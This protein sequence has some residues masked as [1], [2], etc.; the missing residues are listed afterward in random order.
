MKNFEFFPFVVDKHNNVWKY[1]KSKDHFIKLTPWKQGEDRRVN[2]FEIEKLI[3]K[4][5]LTQMKNK[6][7]VHEIINNRWREVD[8]SWVF[9]GRTYYVDSF[10]SYNDCMKAPQHIFRHT[11]KDANGKEH[12]YFSKYRLGFHNGKIVWFNPYH[13]F[14]QLYIW[15]F[16]DINKEPEGYNSWS[17]AKSIRPIYNDKHEI[18]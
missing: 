10:K 2:R 7:A 3:V 11:H 8:F 17:N 14:P 12:E 15:A 6:P 1:I 18:I 5:A 13:Y 9:R 16:E 4:N